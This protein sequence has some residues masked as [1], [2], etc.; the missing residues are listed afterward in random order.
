MLV[1]ADGR[2]DGAAA[3]SLQPSDIVEKLAVARFSLLDSALAE[4]EASVKVAELAQVAHERL[5][6]LELLT[7]MVQL[8]LVGEDSLDAVGRDYYLRH[9]H[10]SSDRDP[11][12]RSSSRLSRSEV[13]RI[14][15]GITDWSSDRDKIW[16]RLLMGLRIGTEWR[17]RR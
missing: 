7:Q 16:T 11:T 10:T 2:L 1:G 8:T 15:F 9:N 13:A 3:F 5:V 4:F 14:R 17:D 6:E 12:R